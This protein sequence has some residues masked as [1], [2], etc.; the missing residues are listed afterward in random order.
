[1]AVAE[2][3]PPLAEAVCAKSDPI[4][5]R[6]LAC[7]STGTASTAKDADPSR[8]LKNNALFAFFVKKR[9]ITEEVSVL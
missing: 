9:A 3:A 2:L 5:E 7:A 8:I 4:K 1:L 6:V